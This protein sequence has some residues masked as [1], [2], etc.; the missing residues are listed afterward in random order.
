MSIRLSRFYEKPCKKHPTCGMLFYSSTLLDF[1]KD[2]MDN[3]IKPAL[4]TGLHNFPA[5]PETK[6]YSRSRQDHSLRIFRLT[7]APGS[8]IFMNTGARSPG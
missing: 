5:H 2:T 7:G 6:S 4:P 3:S 1:R 8:H